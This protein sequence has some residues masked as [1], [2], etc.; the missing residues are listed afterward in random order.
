[1]F[2]HSACLQRSTAAKRLSTFDNRRIYRSICR[3]A[4]EFAGLTTRET[5]RGRGNSL[6]VAIHTHHTNRERERERERRR[7]SFGCLRVGEPADSSSLIAPRCF[8]RRYLS[9][10]TLPARR[11]VFAEHFE[12]R[13]VTANYR[14]TRLRTANSV[15]RACWRAAGNEQ[16]SKNR[17]NI[18]ASGDTHRVDCS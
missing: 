8:I 6:H 3:V 1:M 13:R 15:V 12:T 2:V 11:N 9:T 16:R 10:D 18:L 7:G 4:F 5:K 14:E 17:G